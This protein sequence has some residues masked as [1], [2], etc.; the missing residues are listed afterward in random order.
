MTAVR[1]GT[2]ELA[3][4]LACYPEKSES[5]SGIL[6]HGDS[7][8]LLGRLAES[9]ASSVRFVFIDPPYNTGNS[10]LLY[11]DS[12]ERTDWVLMLKRCFLACRPLLS[13][14]ASIAVTIDDR[15]M[16][17][18]RI[19]MDHIFGESS[20]VACVAYERSGSAG[21]GQAGV[22]LNT[23]EYVLIY[24]LDR[25]SL[26]DIGSEKPV[27][28]QIMQRYNKILRVPGRR[29]PIEEFASRSG[30][31]VRLYRH[32]GCMI[33]PVSLRDFED[34]REEIGAVYHDNFELIFRSQ[35][36]QKENTFQN[37]I[38]ARLDK[39]SFY[40][41]DY[42]PR[43]GRYRGQEKTLYY[44]NGELCAW[45]KDSATVRGG[46][47]VKRNKLTDIWTH[48]DIPKADLANEGGVTFP[49]SKKPEHLLYRLISMTTDPGDLVLDY[50]AGSGTTCAVA[51][52]MGRS[53]IGIEK[54]DFFESILVQRLKHVV[55]GDPTGVSKLAGFTGGG[56]F[57]YSLSPDL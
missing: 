36:V 30:N 43:R 16:P 45:L 17:Y 6:L 9:H 10:E 15:E 56:S 37:E 31:H 39:K 5:T 53:Y 54:G 7:E 25:S 22:I 1:T 20:M 34:R 50:F 35:N 28:R 38:I 48:A 11:P 12:F 51:H 13:S 49:R 44:Y 18:L 14:R 19:M 55:E 24:S 46:E 57:A 42:I 47:L 41:V 4:P 26:N 27:D 23:K 32:E 52:K 3:L 33:E 8:E 21:L 40:S 2:G 29:E